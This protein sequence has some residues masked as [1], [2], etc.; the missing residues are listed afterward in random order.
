MF[1]IRIQSTM[2]YTDLLFMAR[3]LKLKK[4]SSL[5]K[6]ELVDCLQ[7]H[8]SVLF[9][10]HYFFKRHPKEILNNCD[11][12][13]MQELRHPYFEIEIMNGKYYRY[14]MLSF[15][16]YMVKTGNFKDPYTD[17]EFSNAQLRSMDKQL[18]KNGIMKQSLYSMKNNPHKQKY[19]K[20]KREKE[21]SLLGIDR[22]IGSLLSETCDE[23]VIKL[24]S[25]KDTEH[26]CYHTL[27]H[28]FL[29]NFIYLLEQLKNIDVEYTQ[30][31]LR[32][33]KSWV[34]NQNTPLGHIIINMIQNELSCIS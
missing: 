30:N 26:T 12:I 11:P 10:S 4:Y 22:Q 5:R 2:R 29:P 17:T 24:R 20:R 15:Y 23:L 21:D 28:I 25:N 8:V 33:Y 34:T 6:Y 9:I 13:T 19:Y 32:D 27:I 1:F 7:R 16:S 31:C 18:H 3:V 14:N